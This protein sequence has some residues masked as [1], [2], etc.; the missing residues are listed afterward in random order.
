MRDLQDLKITKEQL[1]SLL[2]LVRRKVADPNMPASTEE[3]QNAQNFIKE[4]T[5]TLNESQLDFFPLSEIISLLILEQTGQQTS[6]KKQLK[7]S[8]KI[9]ELSKEI[10]QSAQ[11]APEKLPV[12]IQ[13]FEELTSQK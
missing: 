10:H 11:T 13:I 4:F 3:K 7:K 6:L 5:K 8:Q 12:L 1:T 9:N 2:D